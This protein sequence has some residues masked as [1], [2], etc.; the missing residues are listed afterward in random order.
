M[1]YTSNESG[2]S[3]IYVTPFPGGESK[4]QVSR[5]GGDFPRWR[6]DGRELFYVSLDRMMTAV[7]VDGRGAAFDVGGA[8]PL[9]PVSAPAA[10]GYPYAVTESGDR[11]LVNTN[12]TPAT[13]LTVIL[14]WT[15][16]LPSR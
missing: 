8:T 6:R 2:Q 15:A 5:V 11:F 10:P 14:N 16:T 9:F 12:V 4:W 3:E 13:P 7:A 1:A